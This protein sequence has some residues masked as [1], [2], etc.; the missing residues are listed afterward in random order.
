METDI[1]PSAGEPPLAKLNGIQFGLMTSEDI[2]KLSV[3]AAEN[4]V[5]KPKDL[6]DAKLGL[7]IP[8]G[9]CGTCNAETVDQCQGH[10]AHCHLPL[11]IFHPH[12]VE[13]LLKLLRKIC[14]NCGQLKKK[15]AGKLASLLAPGLKKQLERNA[16]TVPKGESE[17]N[18]S[19]PRSQ[20]ART[21]H[22]QVVDDDYNDSEDD[23]QASLS[24]KHKKRKLAEEFIDTEARVSRKTSEDSEEVICLSSDDEAEFPSSSRKQTKVQSDGDDDERGPD[25][26][27]TSNG[28]ARRTLRKRKRPSGSFANNGPTVSAIDLTHI[29][30]GNP[31]SVA[32]SGKRKRVEND[33]DSQL[34]GVT[35]ADMFYVKPADVKSKGKRRNCKYCSG[36]HSDRYP[37]LLLSSQINRSKG[38]VNGREEHF[39]KGIKMEFKLKKND[40]I[41]CVAP[42]YWAFVGKSS[43]SQTTTVRRSRD[44]LPSEALNILQKIPESAL[45]SLGM[46]PKVARPEALIIEEVPVPPNCSRIQDDV[47]DS[48]NVDYRQGSDRATMIFQK[49]LYKINAIKSTRFG[50]PTFDVA[51]CEASHMQS[52]FGLYLREKGAP[53]AVPG[54]EKKRIDHVGRLQKRDSR[55]SL[56]WLKKHV[57]GKRSGYTGRDV[58]TGDPYLRV[59]EIGIPQQIAKYVTIPERVNKLNME[60]L[61]ECVNNGQSLTG[62]YRACGAVRLVRG[63]ERLEVTRRTSHELQIGDIVH[64]HLRDGDLVFVNRPPSLHKHSLLALRVHIQ[65]LAV[66]TI[67]PA[68]CA[69]LHADFDGDCLHLFVPQS[70]EARAEV[71]QLMTIPEQLLPSPDGKTIIGMS[72]DNILA[73]HLLTSTPVFLNKEEMQQMAIWS[74]RR[75]PIPAIVKS[76]R[77][78]MWAGKQVIDLTIPEDFSIT[79]ND[80]AVE[81]RDGELVS[82]SRKE[83]WLTSTNGLMRALAQYSPVA[84]VNHL[85]CSQSALRE[86]LLSRGFSVS[87]KD[88]YAAPDQK[89]RRKMIDGLM[90]SVTD[91]QNMAINKELIFDEKY[92]KLDA[93]Q[94]DMDMGS[95]GDLKSPEILEDIAVGFFQQQFSEIGEVTTSKISS[96]NQ[97]LAMVRSGSKGS[98]SK[99]LQQIGSLG[100]QLYKGEH[101]LNINCNAKLNSLAASMSCE[102]RWEAR[103]LVRSSLLD[104]LNPLEFY[105]H[106]IAVRT[107]LLHKSLDVSEPGELFKKLMLFLRDIHVAYDGT[108]RNKCGLEIIQF[109]YDGAKNPKSDD[110]PEEKESVMPGEG[111]GILAATAI[112]QPAYQVMLDASP[113]VGSKKI[114]P[115]AFLQDTI[116]PRSRG[117]LKASDRRT[118]L[119]LKPCLCNVNCLCKEKG[120]LSIQDEL[121]PVS[122]EMIARSMS[123]QYVPENSSEWTRCRA[124]GVKLRLP[125]VG[126]IRLDRKTLVEL[127]LK[128]ERVVTAL[129]NAF[130]AKSYAKIMGNNYLANPI[131]FSRSRCDC[132]GAGINSELGPCLHFSASLKSKTTKKMVNRANKKVLELVDALRDV[133]MPLILKT[134]VRGHERI[135][136]AK[137]VWEDASWSPCGLSNDGAPVPANPDG[138]LVVE[139]VVQE[140]SCTGRGEPWSIMKEAC[141]LIDTIDW[142]RSSPYTV[143]EV[144]HSLGVEAARDCILQRL[145]L[146]TQA[147]GCPVSQ[148]HL[149]LVSDL[150]V[151]SGDVTGLTHFGYRD[152]MRSLKTS[153]PFTTG[154]FR[155]PIKTFMEAGEK[156]EEEFL[157]G[158][159]ASSIFGKRVPIGT[160]ADFTLQLQP[161]AILG[162]MEVPM[163][164]V[165]IFDYLGELNSKIKEEFPE[166]PVAAEEAY[167]QDDATGWGNANT[168]GAWGASPADAGDWGGS[169]VQNTGG[170]WDAPTANAEGGW[171]DPA[172]AEE[173]NPW[174]GSLPRKQVDAGSWDAVETEETVPVANGQATVDEMNGWGSEIATDKEHTNDNAWEVV[175]ADPPVSDGWGVDEPHDAQ[176][177]QAWVVP[178][179]THRS[180]SETRE[181]PASFRDYPRS[182]FKPTGANTTPLGKIR[183]FP[184]PPALDGNKEPVSD[185]WTLKPVQED[186]GGWAS[187]DNEP[188]EPSGWQTEP[189]GWQTE[190]SGWQKDETMQNGSG[191]AGNR[192]TRRLDDRKDSKEWEEIV[193]TVRCARNILQSYQAEQ[194][195]NDEH[196]Q[197]LL[198]QVLPYHPRSASKVGCGVAY[199]KVAYHKPIDGQ[200]TKY[201]RASDGQTKCFYLVRTDDSQDDFSYH[202]CLHAYAAKKN[203][204]LDDLYTIAFL[205]RK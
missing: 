72:Q 194:R 156:G 68:I 49:L 138:E 109:S 122:V 85:D 97:L 1:I 12:H 179:D 169:A 58:V 57:L 121:Q 60:K 42:D 126:Q 70:E 113:N 172:P 81:I 141:A 45:A 31:L 19:T 82:Y 134:T 132:T 131:F 142:R 150:M 32:K 170:G 41:E 10:F 100:L 79:S 40:D 90:D 101:L 106:S 75:L 107:D 114:R 50:K 182:E 8:K 168:N 73:T 86:W 93:I 78:P 80:G 110:T 198:T 14:L 61:Q 88:F 29:K 74:T 190:P 13:K 52:L 25:T 2:I 176:A 33:K 17:E 188:N 38:K 30:T 84:A 98:F 48:T 103:G 154:A 4:P 116:F 16:T 105:L 130:K 187:L 162:S 65:D 175:V 127:N 166:T 147:G 7:P 26:P 54:K 111:V 118:I 59:E 56:E 159:L 71:H 55:W 34:N 140:K 164:S 167:V 24:S 47:F 36:A 139:V 120:A 178:E 146:A 137:L 18:V 27:S 5:T 67:N 191:R 11:P 95:A 203:P 6:V 15:K 69:P 195:L 205:S 200:T 76:A 23:V 21:P 87:L 145:T 171:A 89:S 35:I 160:G 165:D 173:L 62:R 94:S 174:C 133:M 3:Y 92:Q 125:W 28:T 83:N 66:F 148:T 144:R 149:K 22:R 161:K 63:S 117:K 104:G 151:H 158:V 53:K 108:V 143:Q 112:A 155:A 129:E 37:E 20:R 157:S 99:V 115:L 183:Q 193:E 197:V 51:G 135:E 192:M 202:K 204:P 43:K 136:S 9:S 180:N 196:H 152:L 77:G 124:D 184:T 39:S 119:R 96:D 44:L 128:L 91:F 153:A 177:T 64:R 46:H 199:F 186:A 189:S 123:I 102:A 163:Q 181:S 185:G 201:Q